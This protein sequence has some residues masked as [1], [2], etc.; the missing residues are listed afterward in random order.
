LRVSHSGRALADLLLG[1]AE[2][3][4]RLPF[5]IPAYAFGFGLGYSRVGFSDPKIF[6]VGEQSAMEVTA[7]NSGDRA[8]ATIAQAYAHDA[9]SWALVLIRRLVGFARVALEPEETR[10]V[11]IPLDLT[12][13]H[14]RIAPG[15]WTRRDG[16]WRIAVASHSRDTSTDTCAAF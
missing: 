11:R 4:G 12:A 15:E 3:G 9:T 6:M 14:H 16:D 13:L 2:P 8:T 5:A 10:R 7:R 1:K